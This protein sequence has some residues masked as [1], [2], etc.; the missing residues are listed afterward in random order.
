MN[1]L[2]MKIIYDYFFYKIRMNKYVILFLFCEKV[3]ILRDIKFFF[4]FIVSNY[5]YS[6]IIYNVFN[7]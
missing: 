2:I 1:K 7:Y 3:I 5:V 6:I 4:V